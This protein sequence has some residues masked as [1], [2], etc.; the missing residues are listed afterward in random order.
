MVAL[1]ALNLGVRFA[2][3]VC[4]LAVVSY[5]AHR[6]VGNP[7]WATPAAIVAPLLFAV[8]W[9]TFAAPKAAVLVPDPWKVGV[10]M[11]LLLLPAA[12]LADAGKSTWAVAYGSAVVVNAVLVAWWDQ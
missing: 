1:Q 3:E 5:L 9:G 12:G 7:G 8:V 4:A 2:L 6:A 10:Q 11:L